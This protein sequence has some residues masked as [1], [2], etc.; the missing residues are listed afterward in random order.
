MANVPVSACADD[1]HAAWGNPEDSQQ[2]SRLTADHR[3]IVESAASCRDRFRTRLPSVARDMPGPTALGHDRADALA[4][5]DA[6]R[7]LEARSAPSRR[8]R[9]SLSRG[10][11]TS[12]AAT[13]NGRAD[14][15]ARKTVRSEISRRSGGYG[16]SGG[17]AKDVDLPCADATTTLT[18]AAAPGRRAAAPF[19][20]PWPTTGRE[21]R[22]PPAVSLAS[23]YGCRASLRTA[24]ATCPVRS[25]SASAGRLL[26]L[27]SSRTSRSISRRSAPRRWRRW[28]RPR[29][30]AA[31]R[32]LRLPPAPCRRWC[33]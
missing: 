26:Q 23:G 28:H 13:R 1:A 29:C 7:P 20:R 15:I 14:G 8:A 9:V 21:A 32:A 18:A 4:S 2:S 30:R 11:Q 16:W 6:R 3:A 19:F 10:G 33:R 22:C 25:R 27:T 5:R 24:D 17:V 12:C 31:R